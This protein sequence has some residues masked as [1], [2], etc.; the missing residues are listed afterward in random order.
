MPKVYLKEKDGKEH[1]WDDAHVS[2]QPEGDNSEVVIFDDDCLTL[3]SFT[4]F[5]VE[6][7][8]VEF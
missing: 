5:F 7:L 8:R 4:Y 3:A 1:T 2:M 6:A